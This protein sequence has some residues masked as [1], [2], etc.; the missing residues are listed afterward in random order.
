MM[1]FEG[2]R[3]LYVLYYY[4]QPK[5]LFAVVYALQLH[6]LVNVWRLPTNNHVKLYVYYIYYNFDCRLT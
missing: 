1:L 2:I 6:A 5:I 4:L 3:I